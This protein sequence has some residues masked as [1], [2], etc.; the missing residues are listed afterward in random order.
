MAADPVGRETVRVVIWRVRGGDRPLPKYMTSGAAGCDLAADLEAPITLAPLERT[1]V[2]TGF[3]IALPPGF[4]AQ[5]RPRS[6][7][8]LREGITLLNAPGTIDEDYRGEIKVILAN[9]G[10]EPRTVRPGDRIAQ[11]VVARVSRA[12]WDLVAVAP[13]EGEALW[14]ERGAGGFGHTGAST[15]AGGVRRG[16]EGA[17]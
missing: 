3:A 1:L 17:S 14:T 16:T 7:L 12:D 11:L 8:A 6:G 5:V 9:L 2:P 15:D 13:A 10:A 4:E